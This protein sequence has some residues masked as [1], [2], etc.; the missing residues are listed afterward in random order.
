[1]V[2][3]KRNSTVTITIDPPSSQT[4]EALC[5]KFFTSGHERISRILNRR[6]TAVSRAIQMEGGDMEILTGPTDEICIR[7]IFKKH[8]RSTHQAANLTC[9]S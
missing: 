1:M 2:L 4:E 6:L 9:L 7:L 8:L 5:L 3:A